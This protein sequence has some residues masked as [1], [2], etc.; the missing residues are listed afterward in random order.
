MINKK[1][2]LALIFLAFA[3]FNKINAQAEISNE[4]VMSSFNNLFETVDNNI[5]QFRNLVTEDFFIF[6]NSRRYNTEEFID[7]VK[8]FDIIST[9]R[10]FENIVIDIDCNSAHMSLT[11]F[12]EFLINT[13]EGKVK[14][15]F[16]W[17]ESVYLVKVNNKLK[18]KFYFSEAI[19][20]KTTNVETK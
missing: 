20:T 17:L 19:E 2:Y 6:E 5:D 4:D 8:T 1:H 7:F 9:K 18:F 3:P 10:S 13:P 16:E 11:H 15:E 14:L 12:G